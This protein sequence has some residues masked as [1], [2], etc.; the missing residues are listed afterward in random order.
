MLKGHHLALDGR[1]L[2]QRLPGRSVSATADGSQLLGIQ[3]QQ[4]GAREHGPD[5]IGQAQRA[6]RSHEI[7]GPLNGAI[8][9]GT[10]EQFTDADVLLST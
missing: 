3:T 10:H 6:H 2:A 1:Q 9:D 8:L 7:L 4:L 5:F